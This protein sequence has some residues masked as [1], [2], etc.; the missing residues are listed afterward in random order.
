MILIPLQKWRMVS[1]R[2]SGSTMY[3][4]GATTM[5]RTIPREDLWEAEDSNFEKFRRNEKPRLP[6]ASDKARRSAKE[7]PTSRRVRKMI[8][9]AVGG[10]HRR[11]QKKIY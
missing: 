7:T 8:S 1:R 10:I 2:N 9:R 4:S 3:R 6:V 5:D 11:R